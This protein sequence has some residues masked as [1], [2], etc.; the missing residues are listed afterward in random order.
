M[1][2]IVRTVMSI[3]WSALAWLVFTGLGLLSMGALGF[4]LYYAAW[5]ALAPFH[6]NPNRWTGDWVWPA[7]I[8]AGMLWPLSFLVA[9]WMHLH[10]E[11]LGWS[12]FANGLAYA[13]ILWLG[14][15]LVW[16]AMLATRHTA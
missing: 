12:R 15:A 2:G 13:L 3:K 6:G 4:A 8:G 14:A 1:N 16:W 7:M 10:L 9:G 11:K 5:P